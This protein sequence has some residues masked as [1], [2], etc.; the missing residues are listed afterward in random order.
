MPLSRMSLYKII[1][2]PVTDEQLKQVKKHKRLSILF[3][4]LLA[5]SAIHVCLLRNMGFA[6]LFL[7]VLVFIVVTKIT[8]KR[9]ENRL[10]SKNPNQNGA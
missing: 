1:G 6:A 2:R 9:S 4:I 3:Y 10:K 8:D 7:S 5:W